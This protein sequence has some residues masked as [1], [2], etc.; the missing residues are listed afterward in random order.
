MLRHQ[1]GEHEIRPAQPARHMID[2]RGLV[3]PGAREAAEAGIH[4]RVF[5]G[6]QALLPDEFC[7]GGGAV[8]RR[9]GAILARR[10]RVRN[11]FRQLHVRQGRLG[12]P[13]SRAA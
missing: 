4:T 1:L 5:E 13:G 11:T 10:T 7:V 6:E 3:Q 9:H 8:E 12:G 2:P